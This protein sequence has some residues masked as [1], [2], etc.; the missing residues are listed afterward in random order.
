ME[1]TFHGAARE[2]TGSCH[3]VRIG[4]KT[5]LLDAGLFQGR[6]AE[7]R[8][9]NIKL[10]VDPNR[11]DAVVL[12]HAHIDHAGRLPYL[13]RRGYRGPIFTTHATRDLC[14]VM[15]ADSAHIQ[16]KD[17]EFLARRNRV[18]EEPLYDR[19]DV[20]IAM[21]SMRGIDYDQWTDVT[22]GLRV[23]L[24]DAGHIL[25][26]AS[27][28]LEW[29]DGTTTRRLAFSGD[30]GRAGLSIIRDPVPPRD[31]DAV[32]MESTYGNREHP[33]VEDARERLAA[34][35]RET[36]ARG[37]RILIPAF[38]VGRTQELIYT[39]H[40]LVLAGRIPRIPVIIDSPLATEATGVFTRHANLFDMSES[41]VRQFQ[42]D[43][44][45]T[46]GNSLVEFTESPEAS[47]AAMQRSGPMIV[48]AA[49]GMV[50]SGRILHHL[51]HGAADPRN[52]ILIVGFQA[53]HTLGRRIVERRPVIKVFGEEV[54][55][56]AQVE[57]LNGYSAHAGHAE[58]L[59]WLGAVRKT[60]PRLKHTWLVHGEPDAQDSLASDLNAHGFAASCPSPGDRVIV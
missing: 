30:I 7:V 35:V 39:F 31:V 13:A 19:G 49:S 4:G 32:I 59:S 44:A 2:V 41:F 21:R 24:I 22:D 12:S 6:R 1:L 23:Q 55:L 27:V 16:E 56:R 8:A 58:L 43:P 40:E 51:L 50:E 36:A 60:S 48:I 9:K 14:G 57:V 52:T 3:V 37:G 29:R 33:A 18:H 5:V 11:I 54:E 53:A 46:L 15:L 17:A 34:T 10:P 38:A 28:V 42:A 26:S 47:K 20:E 45:G 25:G